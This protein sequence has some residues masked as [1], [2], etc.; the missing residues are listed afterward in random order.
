M[1][2]T[3]QNITP[4]WLSLKDAS[5]YG[6]I[7]TKR[8]KQLATE[9]KVKGFQDPDSGRGDWVFDR[10]SIDEYREGQTPRVRAR[11]TAL[12]ILRRAM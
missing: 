7:G 5:V 6:R 10:L 9:G 12:A 8:L 4:R 1:T 2:A 11:T 3:A